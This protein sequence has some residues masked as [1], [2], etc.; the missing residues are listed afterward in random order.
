MAD[1]PVLTAPAPTLDRVADGVSLASDFGAVWVALSVAQVAL[2]T[3]SLRSAARRLA[4][5][6]LV[7]LVLT[8][9]LKH[10]FAVPR[11]DTSSTATLARTPSSSRFPSGHTLAAFTAA[12]VVPRSPAARVAALCVACTVAWARVRVGHHRPADVVAGAA[13]GIA[14][15]VAILGAAA[16]LAGPGD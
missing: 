1:A 3:N 8:R 11:D 13:A 12:L 10:Y 6:G 4:G 5:A 14:G 16:A 7:S 9:I 2:G 15:G